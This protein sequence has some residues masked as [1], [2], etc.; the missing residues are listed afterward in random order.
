M[1]HMMQ[2]DE[3]VHFRQKIISQCV[4][5]ETYSS[6]KQILQRT[7]NQ[8]PLLVSIGKTSDEPNARSGPATQT[9]LFF[10]RTIS[11]KTLFTPVQPSARQAGLYEVYPRHCTFAITDLFKGKGWIRS[12]TMNSSDMSLWFIQVRSNSFLMGNAVLVFSPAF[13]C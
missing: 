12:D 6:L 7:A 9:I 13:N 1:S 8:L 5:S 3:Q 4:W 11:T 10:D 2:A